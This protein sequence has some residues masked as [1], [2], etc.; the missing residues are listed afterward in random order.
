[1][2]LVSAVPSPSRPTKLEQLY[3]ALGTLEEEAGGPF[4][5]ADA[6]SDL[7]WPQRGIYVFFSHDTA[8]DT[9]PVSE[10][11]ITR[12]G[13]VGDSTGSKSTLWDRLRAHRGTV[14]SKY[15]ENSG[16]HRG[17]IFRKHVGR[18]II[19]R[20]GLDDE[21]PYWG[22]PHRE[23][24]D[25]ISTE[26]IR[27]QEHSLEQRVSEYIRTLPFLAVDIPGEPGPDCERSMLEKNLIALVS[28]ARRTTPG[29]D[30]SGWLGYNS[31][32]AEIA[33][34]SLWNIDH[35]NGFY[36]GSVIRDL[37]PHIENTE[38]IDRGG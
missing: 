38:R 20:D 31:P 25:D 17:S 37:K 2:I 3:Q 16:N 29:V 32:H 19:E 18:A 11:T 26:Y 6:T 10:W 7:N 8:L 4:Y 13:T 22:Q 5:L 1:M 30:Q 33:R 24:P 12:I 36:S 35:V 34:T 14:S 23:L 15:G 27:E 9:D 28:H 21:F